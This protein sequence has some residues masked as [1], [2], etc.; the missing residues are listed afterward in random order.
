MN[1]GIRKYPY[2]HW[3][4]ADLY[5]IKCNYG[6]EMGIK[7]L[8]EHFNTS[9]Q[10]IKFV[11]SSNHIYRNKDVP[12]NWKKSQIDLLIDR[13]EIC[14]DSQELKALAA[15]LGKSV[16]AMRTMASQY[17]LSRRRRKAVRS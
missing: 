17:G 15:Q 10:N 3:S 2:R 13:F 14:K 4:Q 6:N 5:F 9:P 11:V 16:N 8:A 7:E 1:R 12:K